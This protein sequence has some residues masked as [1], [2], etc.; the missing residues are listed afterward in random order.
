MKTCPFNLEGVLAEAPFRWAA[1]HLP[2]TRRWIARLDDLVGNGRINPVKKWWWD[3]DSD[4][5]GNLVPARRV[6]ER[7]LEFRPPMSPDKQKLACFPA[8]MAPPPDAG[9]TPLDR[10]EGVRRYRDAMRPG[11]AKSD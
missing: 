9:P 10:K 6:N 8:D 11:N 7:E 3:I 4:A 5:D 2:F 1:M